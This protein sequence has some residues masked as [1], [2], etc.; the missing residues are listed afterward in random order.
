MTASYDYLIVLLSYCC[1]WVGDGEYYAQQTVSL[2]L[3]MKLVSVLIKMYK[4]RT[5]LINW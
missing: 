5:A 1:Q 3:T 2:L 4:T